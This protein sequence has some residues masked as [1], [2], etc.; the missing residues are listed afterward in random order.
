MHHQAAQLQVQRLKLLRQLLLQLPLLPCAAAALPVDAAD[1]AAERPSDDRAPTA[2]CLG[3]RCSRNVLAA[4]W[5][6][7]AAMRTGTRDRDRS[8]EPRLEDE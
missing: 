6:A 3:R 1:D 5:A 7:G 8:Q 4:K 2:S